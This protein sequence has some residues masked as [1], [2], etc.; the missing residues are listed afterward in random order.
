MNYADVCVLILAA[1][2]G[3]RMHSE[4]PKVLQ[5]LLAT[6]MLDYIY[7]ALHFLP[8]ENIFTVIGHKAEDIEK[9]FS[10]KTAENFILQNEQLGT[11]HALQCSWD[12]IRGSKAKYCLVIN[13]DTPLITQDILEFFME[14]SFKKLPQLDITFITT[15]LKDV[16][17]FGR[18]VR[19]N[20]K[21]QAII[22]AKDYDENIYQKPSGEIN[23]GIYLLKTACLEDIL[24][25][26]ENKN[27]NGE[28]YITDLIGHAAQ[29]NMQ[30]DGIVCEESAAL[31]GINSPKELI[32]AEEILQKEIIEKHLANNVFIHQKEQVRIAP[33]VQ[34]AAGVHI[35]GPCE[36]YGNTQISSA[37]TISS[38]C[39]IE[40]CIIE[41]NCTIDSFSHLHDAKLE[42]NCSVGPY[43]RLRPESILAEDAKIGNFV[44]I[45]KSNIGKGSKV[46]HFSYIGDSTLETDVN[47]GA[48]TITCNYDGNNKSKTVIKKGA[49]IGSNSSL[50]APVI[51]G[52]NT[53]I[54]AGSVITNDVPDNHLA[55]TRAEQKNIPRK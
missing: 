16:A 1:G 10:H 7:S 50:V 17:A 35:F 22:E 36:I 2:K 40:N 45:K 31:L 28:Y 6:P 53:R 27:K 15:V 30:V 33:H 3:T 34:I 11:G 51:I 44:E 42:N 25:Q 8:E 13:G 55:I 39:H 12:K 26:L 37:C 14:E 23:A 43:A 21:L 48:G 18:V 29:K 5:E 9:K 32:F 49:F 4:K 20:N 38:H 19:K 52:E 41:K 24:F 46:N 47:I 54:G